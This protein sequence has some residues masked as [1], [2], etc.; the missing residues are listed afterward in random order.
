MGFIFLFSFVFAQPDI[1]SGGQMMPDGGV[2]HWLKN[3]HPLLH[4][5]QSSPG[6][7]TD[8]DVLIIG[9]GLGGIG[10]A[11]MLSHH[12]KNLKIV[13]LDSRGVAEGATSHNGG[14][15]QPM[16]ENF[17][18]RYE[19]L[20]EERYKRSKENYPELS[21]K[22]LRQMA[23]D[24]A[25]TMLKFGVENGKLFRSVLDKYNLNPDV[26]DKGWMRL[27]NSQQE[28]RDFLKDVE[29]AK[30]IGLSMEIWSAEKITRLTG[31]K[32]EFGGRFTPGYG[33]YHP[34]KF[35]TQLFEHLLQKGILLYTHTRVTKVDW[36]RPVNQPV[37]VHTERGL[38]RAQK[39]IV[40]TDAY[41]SKLIPEMTGLVEPFQSQVVTYDKISNKEV[42]LLKTG[43]TLT[44]RDGDLYGNIPLETKYT[45][46]SGVERG[47]YL[48]GGGPDRL[49]P[50]ADRPPLSQEMF[51][52]IVEQ[53]S[54]R[55]PGLKH[56]LVSS[57]W[58]G[59]FGFTPQRLPF[60]SYVTHDGVY[61]PRVIMTVGS[62]G[63]GGGMSLF[64]GHLAG[65]IALL[66]PEQGEELLRQYDPHRFFKLP[67][68]VSALNEV[69][70]GYRMCKHFFAK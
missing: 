63:Y 40:A 14:N 15:F 61:D 56:W 66:S 1:D 5:Y 17:I 51:D 44:E 62:Q 43:W 27:A 35:A 7:P 9:S 57:T 25:L 12:T 4:N 2:P 34:Y 67:V 45:D 37:L 24:Q 59:V 60:L 31:I 50:D 21:E 16:P 52:V 32:T 47:L 3:P 23:A 49:V 18:D 41:T 26:S 70:S 48:V 29:L 33:N 42:P 68:L 28:E 58:T 38:I 36:S 69:S 22:E 54:Y 39:V 30:S 64:G 20:I 8:V 13:V 65:Q 19:S 46:A 6:L 11:E 55:F 53:T 10:A